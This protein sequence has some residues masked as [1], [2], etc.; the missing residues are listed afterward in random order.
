MQSVHTAGPRKARHNVQRNSAAANTTELSK[1]TSQDF[2]QAFRF[3]P[4]CYFYCMITSLSAHYV[5]NT[6]VYTLL[7]KGSISNSNI[8]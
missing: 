7:G 8:N 3:L 4:Q 5:Q 1:L 6:V 2:T